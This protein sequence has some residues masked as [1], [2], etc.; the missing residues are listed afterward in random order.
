LSPLSG[1]PATRKQLDI[2]AQGERK[3]TTVSSGASTAMTPRLSLSAL[4]AS[5][6]CLLSMPACEQ[7]A[8]LPGEPLG[9]FEIQ[10]TISSN[11]CGA[12]LGAPN[13]YVFSAELSREDKRLHWRQNG[14]IVSGTIDSSAQAV[15]TSTQTGEAADQAGNRSGCVV[16]HTDTLTVKLGAEDPP[17]TLGGT[18]G[19]NFTVEVP[20]NCIGQ[21][22]ASGGTFDDLPCQALYTLTATRTKAP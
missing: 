11:S 6:V 7:P 13:P 4:L 3:K 9:T 2:V 5:G 10:A 22:V 16:T 12:G 21:L 8:A 19:F 18:L 17:T 15:I 14:V 1:R 20:A